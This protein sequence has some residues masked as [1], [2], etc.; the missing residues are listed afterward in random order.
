MTKFPGKEKTYLSAD[1]VAEDD[2]HSA[3]PAY[4]L[5][6]VTLSGM[7]PPSMTLKVR[8]LVIL[9]KNRRGGPGSGLEMEQD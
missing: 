7:P 6:S 2:L 5:K 4:F 9:P 3:F 1:V 8:S